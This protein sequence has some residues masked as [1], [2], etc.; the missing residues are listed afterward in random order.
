[1]STLLQFL[2]GSRQA[3]IDVANCR[4]SLLLGALFVLSAGFAREYNGKDLLHEPWLLLVPLVASLGTSLVLYFLL[5]M[6]AV[7]RTE[8]DDRRVPSYRRF[9]SLYWMTAPLAWIYAIPVEQ[10]MSAGD[11]M[12][13]NLSFLGIVSLWRVLLITRCVS[14]LF[15]ASFVS[16]FFLVM[17]FADSLALVILYFTPLPIFNIMG[18]IALTESEHVIRDTA[19]KVQFFGGITWPVWFIG[20]F[21]VLAWKNHGWTPLEYTEDSSLSISKPL[22]AVAFL[23]LVVWG[24]V[25]PSSQP[26]QKLRREVETQLLDGHVDQAI[27]EMSA[28]DRQAFPPNWDPPPWPGYGQD[29]PPLHKVLQASNDEAAA[30]WVRDV[31]FEKLAIQFKQHESMFSFWH[32]MDDADFTEYMAFFQSNPNAHELVRMRSTEF[33]NLIDYERRADRGRVQPLRTLLKELDI[34]TPETEESDHEPAVA[35]V[36]QAES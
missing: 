4:A 6:A 16:A 5:Y 8:A 17:L 33:I 28:H 31:F 3:I 35:E 2:A 12:R 26:P 23:S 25:L 11:A 34:E 20:S 29:S 10:W 9:L 15:G 7:V 24:F 13:A 1:M 21:V 32:S 30:D 27:Q 36:G 19:C 14:V 18:G 22:W